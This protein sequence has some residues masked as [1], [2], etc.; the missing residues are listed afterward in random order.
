[1]YLN[2]VVAVVLLNNSTL[3]ILEDLMMKMKMITIVMVV[4]FSVE[5]PQMFHVRSRHNNIKHLKERDNIN[6]IIS[7][8]Q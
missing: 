8:V 6:M 7:Y 2:T 5:E 4:M 3:I 1:M